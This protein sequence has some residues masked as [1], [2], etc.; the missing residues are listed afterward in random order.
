MRCGQCS[1]RTLSEKKPDSVAPITSSPTGCNKRLG[2]DLAVHREI[3]LSLVMHAPLG[4]GVCVSSPDPSPHSV[5]STQHPAHISQ[6][7]NAFASTV[8]LGGQKEGQYPSPRWLENAITYLSLLSPTQEHSQQGWVLLITATRP[9]NC[10]EH[11]LQMKFRATST[12]SGSRK[13][14]I[15]AMLFPQVRILSAPC[16]M[17]E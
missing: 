10:L 7:S 6:H 9:N 17:P 15:S 14:K 4:D 1:S 16:R 3:L 11:L 8:P 12:A 2:L 5:Q 13:E